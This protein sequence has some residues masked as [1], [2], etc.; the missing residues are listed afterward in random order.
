MEL[1]NTP[2][3]QSHLFWKVRVIVRDPASAY[4]QNEHKKHRH[5]H[6]GCGAAVGGWVFSPII[7][8]L[9]VE[10]IEIDLRQLCGALVEGHVS[11]PFIGQ[12]RWDEL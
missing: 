8:A 7:D 6:R 12:R 4:S 11:A 5:D 10:R 2:W 3:L 9:L 1:G